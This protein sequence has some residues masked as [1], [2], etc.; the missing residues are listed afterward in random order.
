S[1]PHPRPRHCC[2]AASPAR[3]RPHLEGHGCD[4]L[5]FQITELAHHVIEE[6]VPGLAPR[7]ALATGGVKAV[8]FVHKA[9][10]IAGIKRQLG[11]CEHVPFG[12]TGWSHPLP[13]RRE[14]VIWKQSLCQG[15]SC[16]PGNV[17]VGLTM[18]NEIHVASMMGSATT[19][20]STP[21]P[22]LGMTLTGG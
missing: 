6:M 16:L 12:P 20:D 18:P 10:D 11:D 3:S 1:G 5:A 8:P 9:L 22:S 2:R 4:R 14:L 15:G 17:V 7:K 19:P 21:P 13:P